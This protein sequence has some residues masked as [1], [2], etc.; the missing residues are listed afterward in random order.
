MSLT[1]NQIL[2]ALDEGSR[3]ES[4]NSQARIFSGVLRE[5]HFMTG[6]GR[7]VKTTQ[8]QYQLCLH[9]GPV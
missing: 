5:R 1:A 3:H 9:P 6:L 7:E 4:A 8:E 2:K